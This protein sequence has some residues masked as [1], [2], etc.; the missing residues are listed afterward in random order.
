M[1]D[2]IINQHYFQDDILHQIRKQYQTF[3]YVV[4]DDFYSPNI[5]EYISEQ[6]HKIYP[7]KKECDYYSKIDDTYR[8]LATINGDIILNQSPGLKDIYNHPQLKNWIEKATQLTLID[9]NKNLW[10]VFN[11]HHGNKCNHGWHLDIEAVVM[12]LMIHENISLSRKGGCLRLV[13]DWLILKEKNPTLN[14]SELYEL[15]KQDNKTHD[16]Y[17]KA[18]QVILLQGNRVLH[19]VSNMPETNST[20]ITFLYSWQDINSRDNTNQNGAADALYG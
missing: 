13:P 9:C 12:N 7:E 5:F 8:K 20:R 10:A 17:L 3:G 4:L 14:N 11:I 2:Q 1:W 6:F 18:N 16:V 15:I 19:S